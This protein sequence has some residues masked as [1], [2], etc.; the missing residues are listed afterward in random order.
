M[1]K[2]DLQIIKARAEAATFDPTMR[3][4]DTEAPLYASRDIVITDD[5][6]ICQFNPNMELANDAALFANARSDILA[7]VAEVERLDKLLYD[8]IAILRD[9]PTK[10]QFFIP[11]MEVY[12][13]W[14]LYYEETR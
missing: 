13:R 12:R 14:C 7:L 10:S 9:T 11:A 6:I 5:R 8:A 1:N 4:G 2:T 3:V